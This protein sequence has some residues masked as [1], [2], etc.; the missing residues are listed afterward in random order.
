MHSNQE[1]SRIETEVRERLGLDRLATLAE[2]L[3]RYQEDH[4]DQLMWRH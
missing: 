4:A 1:W 3:Q 2:V